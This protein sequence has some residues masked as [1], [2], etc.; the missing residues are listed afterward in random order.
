M[1]RL[2]RFREITSM[3]SIFFITFLQQPQKLLE[4][5]QTNHCPNLVQNYS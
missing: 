1:M 2:K 5:C 4:C 3:L